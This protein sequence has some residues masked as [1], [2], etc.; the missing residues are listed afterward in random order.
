ML[1]KWDGGDGRRGL[2]EKVGVKERGL[3][4]VYISHL[5]TYISTFI[6]SLQVA[7]IDLHH[8]SVA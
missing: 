3:A 4:H 6:A 7:T 5:Y 8:R 2:W 1:N